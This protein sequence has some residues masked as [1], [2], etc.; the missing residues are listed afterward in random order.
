[1]KPRSFSVQQTVHITLTGGVAG[2]RP[3]GVIFSV[4]YGKA[5]GNEGAMRTRAPGPSPQEQA[6]FLV[7]KDSVRMSV[8]ALPQHFPAFPV[9]TIK[10]E[11]ARH[12]ALKVLLLQWFSPF[13]FLH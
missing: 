4:R 1:M 10:F 9:I 13:K 6:T 3:F 7:G 2:P 12:K 8:G 5:P 11:T